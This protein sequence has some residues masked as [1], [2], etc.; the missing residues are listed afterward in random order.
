M[1]AGGSAASV[2]ELGKRSEQIGEIIDRALGYLSGRRQNSVR[3]AELANASDVVEL[4][5]VAA[6]ASFDV[7]WH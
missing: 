1:V 7:W 4:D 2:S 3:I 5:L 6:Y